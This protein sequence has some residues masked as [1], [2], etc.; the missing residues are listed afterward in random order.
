MPDKDPLAPVPS[1]SEDDGSATDSS[2]DPLA[3]L[4]A[5]RLG[6]RARLDDLTGG[7]AFWPGRSSGWS[8]PG[9]RNPVVMGL[10]GLAGVAVGALLVVLV[11]R[12][13]AASAPAG[14]TAGRPA[15]SVGRSPAASVGTPRGSAV[16][17]AGVSQGADAA[18]PTGTTGGSGSGGEPGTTAVAGTTAPA[19]SGIWVAAAGAVVRPGLYL[20]RTDARVSELVDAAGGL[21]ADAD[22][23]RVNLAA[24]LHDGE[25]V[26][27]P[28][29][30][31][32]SPPSVV[33]AD[34]DGGAGGAGSD[35][36]GSGSSGS[37]AGGEAGAS[38]RAPAVSRAHP[39][40]LNRASP[41]ELEALPGVG[42]ATAAA[43]VEY[44]NSH[45]P[46]TSVDELSRVRGIGPAKLE[47]VRALVVV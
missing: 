10:I 39:L 8:S 45:G 14:A 29:R 16:A 41:N 40:D 38:G 17:P 26:Y 20:V 28:H 6:W 7:L 18:A 31:E 42:P 4:I 46:F 9:A 43:I 24:R 13:P 44:R 11:L 15:V 3:A 12:E 19:P 47:Q 5:P 36:S 30:G 22:A 21:G 23:D 37:G 34:G 2:R 1:R 35:G 33:R 27:V 32:Q 25:R